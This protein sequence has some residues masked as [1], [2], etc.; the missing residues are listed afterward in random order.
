MKRLSRME[1][2]IAHEVF[3]EGRREEGSFKQ[4]LKEVA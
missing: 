1:R 2:E 3:V 4:D